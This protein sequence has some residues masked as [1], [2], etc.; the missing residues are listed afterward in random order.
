MLI[1]GMYM[2]STLKLTYYIEAVPTL[3]PWILP[4]DKILSSNTTTTSEVISLSRVGL[5]C[6]CPVLIRVGCVDGSSWSPS[7]S[8]SC[9][10]SCSRRWS[11]SGGGSG[12]GCGGG[13]VGSI[14]D[15]LCCRKIYSVYTPSYSTTM[16]CSHFALVPYTVCVYHINMRV[17]HVN[18]CE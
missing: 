3:V 15:P 14:W 8:C 16:L 18:S 12:C 6:S 2:L 5:P 4:P 10:R 11:W 9:S 7:C 17:F 1:Y 13:G